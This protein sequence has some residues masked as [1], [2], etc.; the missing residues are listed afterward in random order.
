MRPTPL[1]RVDCCPELKFSHIQ[2][3]TLNPAGRITHKDWSA[4]EPCGALWD[5]ILL[6]GNVRRMPAC[7][8]LPA[9]RVC[10]NLGN[11]TLSLPFCV[12]GKH[13]ATS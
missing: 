9:S 8:A 12:V 13:T 5:A 2:S 7:S 6:N 3:S 4:A 11:L 10:S 1:T